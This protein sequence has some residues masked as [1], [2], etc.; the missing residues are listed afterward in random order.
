M[1]ES[2]SFIHHKCKHSHLL[3]VHGVPGA[4]L[5]FYKSIIL[6]FSQLYKVGAI[7]MPTERMMKLRFREGN[8][9]VQE[10]AVGKRQSLD[11][12]HSAA[13]HS[14]A[15]HQS[16]GSRFSHLRAQ[17]LCFRVSGPSHSGKAPEPA[18][19]LLLLS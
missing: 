4:V 9:L 8:R 17:E 13:L 11:R 7:V 14:P 3:S 2:I 10:H 18:L 6:K 15:P 12:L 5:R 1:V 16:G 19:E